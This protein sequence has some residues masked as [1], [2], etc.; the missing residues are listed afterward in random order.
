MSPITT[1]QDDVWTRSTAADLV[2][3]TRF[4]NIV[5]ALKLGKPSISIGYAEKNDVLMA[6][7]GLGD[8]C[9]HIER[10]SLDRLMRQ[11]STLAAGRET[12]AAGIRVGAGRLPP[13]AAASGHDPDPEARRRGAHAD[14]GGCPCL[15]AGHRPSPRRR[16][17]TSRSPA[18]SM[19]GSCA[20][21]SKAC[22]A[23]TIPIYALS[24]STT[25][26]PTTVSRSRNN[27]LA[28]TRGSRSS[29][30]RAISASTPPS[31]EAIDWASSEYFLL[32]CADDLMLPGCL[33]H[34]VAILERHPEAGF[35]YGDALRLDLEGP[36]PDLGGVVERATWQDPR[37]RRHHRALLP[38][39]RPITFR[40][41]ASSSRGPRRK[42]GP[43]TI[44]RRC[45]TRTTSKCG[46]A[47]PASDPRPARPAPV[48][49]LRSHGLSRKMAAAAGHSA[50]RPPALPWHDLAA[51]ESFFVP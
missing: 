39:R 16:S 18:I 24:L 51:F 12:Y 10:L 5:S 48:G 30:I 13:A 23:R 49:V 45:R 7:M 50:E 31:N 44:D 8:F 4:H 19:A 36:L 22:S 47:S 15:N 25:P 20:T 34:A 41:R 32:L 9:Q 33:S 11:L 3:A 40:D 35:V 29:P 2:V 28:R 17:S 26:R 46:C 21:A 43:A 6:A 1:L 42:S 27:S 37:G 14:G 38:G